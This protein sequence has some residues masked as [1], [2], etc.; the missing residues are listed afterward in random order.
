MFPMR[1]AIGSSPPLFVCL[2]LALALMSCSGEAT[3]TDRDENAA[4]AEMPRAAPIQPEHPGLPSDPRSALAAIHA[5]WMQCRDRTFGPP[6]LQ[7][8]DDRASAASVALLPRSRTTLRELQGLEADLFEPLSH[9]SAMRG[10][11]VSDLYRWFLP[12]LRLDRIYCRPRAALVA[13]YVDRAARG[14]SDHL[15]VIADLRLA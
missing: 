6:A 15:P 11:D 5:E 8:C 1:S 10:D 3:N 9:A 14:I 13:S 12:L 2:G 4:E 7:A